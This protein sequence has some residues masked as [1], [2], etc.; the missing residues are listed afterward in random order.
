MYNVFLCEN[1]NQIIAYSGISQLNFVQLI[2]HM[3]QQNIKNGKQGNLS[4]LADHQVT[5]TPRNHKVDLL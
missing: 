3:L 2:Q 4:Q 1:Y 5:Q